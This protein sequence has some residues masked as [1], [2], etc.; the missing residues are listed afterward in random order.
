M[1]D[2]RGI[3][4]LLFVRF[5][6][7]LF[8]FNVETQAIVDTH[9]LVRYPD[10]G[11]KGNDISTPIHVKQFE[12]HDQKRSSGHVMAEAI[13]AGKQIKEF[14]AEHRSGLGAFF[15]AILARLTK[16][17]FVGHG[18]GDACNRNS[19]NQQPCDLVAQSRHVWLGCNRKANR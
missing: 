18:P 7:H 17:L 19:Q 8:M 3:I 4:N 16:D 6:F 10:K 14:A 13:L 2:R 5:D 1:I 9:V 11:E 12:A 15:Q